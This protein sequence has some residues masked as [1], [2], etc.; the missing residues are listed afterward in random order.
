[1]PLIREVNYPYMEYYEAVI[2]KAVEGK[3]PKGAPPV[4][5]MFKAIPKYTGNNLVP[6]SVR[7]IAYSSN[8]GGKTFNMD[9]TIKNTL[10]EQPPPAVRTGW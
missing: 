1:M 3:G 2:R 7:I 5:V 9:V 10:G 4:N 8:D 6:D